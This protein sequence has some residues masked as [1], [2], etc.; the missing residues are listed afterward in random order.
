[1]CFR[2]TSAVTQD[3]E[4]EYLGLA[5]WPRDA[6]QLPVQLQRR[7]VRE[8][9]DGKRGSPSSSCGCAQLGTVGGGGAGGQSYFRLPGARE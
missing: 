2:R 5:A 4:N 1:M 8:P 7:E 9:G 6:G 3:T